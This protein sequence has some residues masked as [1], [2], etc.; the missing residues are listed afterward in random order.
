MKL[1]V[2]RKAHFLQQ[3]SNM[4]GR[5]S[6]AIRL[7]LS[8]Y[9]ALVAAAA[10]EPLLSPG[11]NVGQT[12]PVSCLNRTMYVPCLVSSSATI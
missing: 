2:V 4:P 9:T 11:Y 5:L 3:E 1:H 6:L 10:Q 8:F 12:I 7:V